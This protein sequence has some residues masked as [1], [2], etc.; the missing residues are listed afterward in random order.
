SDGNRLV[1]PDEVAALGP[2]GIAELVPAGARCYVTI[3][4]DALDHALVP[5]CVSAEPDG[6]SYVQ[7]RDALVTLVERV[8]VVGLDLVEVNPLVDSASGATAYLATHIL[9]ETLDAITRQTG[10][11]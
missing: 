5:G 3:D 9:L 4:I 2:T 1:I 6:L 8:E 7:L 10:R 11:S